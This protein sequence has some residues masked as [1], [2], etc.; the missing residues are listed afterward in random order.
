MR[1]LNKVARIFSMF[2]KSKWFDVQSNI[3]YILAQ[4][5]NLVWKKNMTTKY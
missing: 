3:Y 4:T 1:N 5:H 2:G